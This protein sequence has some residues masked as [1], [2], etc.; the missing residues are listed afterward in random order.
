MAS[1]EW[2]ED[3]ASAHDG[4]HSKPKS[5]WGV[6]TRVEFFPGRAATLP[7]RDRGAA[8]ELCFGNGDEVRA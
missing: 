3:E 4:G 2:D 6:S 5:G 1:E 7:T 8:D